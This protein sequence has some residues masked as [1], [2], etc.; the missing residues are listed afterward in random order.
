MIDLIDSE[1]I[2]KLKDKYSDALLVP[3]IS[4]DDDRNKLPLTYAMVIKKITGLN[5][6]TNIKQIN[7]TNHSK[8]VH[9]SDYYQEPVF[10]VMLLQICNIFWWMML[11]QQVEF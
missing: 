2:I 6:V 4:I 7:E 11:L 5:V 8:K 3:V 1:K 10:R 9:W